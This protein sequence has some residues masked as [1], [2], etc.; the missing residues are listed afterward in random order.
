MI[1]F[2]FVIHTTKSKVKNGVNVDI[3]ETNRT[4]F[5]N[6]NSSDVFESTNKNELYFWRF[7]IL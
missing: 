1:F 3:Y 6:E 4:T 2:F 7:K 5:N